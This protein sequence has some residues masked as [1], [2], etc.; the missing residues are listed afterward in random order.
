[1]PARQ[2]RAHAPCIVFIDEIDAVGRVRSGGGNGGG[3]SSSSNERE[4]TLNQVTAPARGIGDSHP[5][6]SIPL[7]CPPASGKPAA[8]FPA[9]TPAA[10]VST[11]TLI[12]SE[13]T[14]V[15]TNPGGDRRLRIT[16]I[17]RHQ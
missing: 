4:N 12:V 8:C 10:I 17:R 3:S 14:V 5:S 16:Q 7:R 1:M 2:A 6:P 15:T 13:M 11:R 9:T